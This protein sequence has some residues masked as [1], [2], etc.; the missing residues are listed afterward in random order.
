MLDKKKNLL[1]LFCWLFVVSMLGCQH[2]P[3]AQ[4]D[5]GTIL[6]IVSDFNTGWLH[7][8][9]LAIKND[10]LKGGETFTVIALNEP[11]TYYEGRV[12]EK[13][14]SSLACPALLPD[15][16]DTN[17]AEGYTCYAVALPKQ[18]SLELGIAMV[19]IEP[20]LQVTRGI[21]HGDINGDYHDNYFTQCNTSEGIRFNIWSD[22]AF[23]GDPIWSGYYYL[24]YDTES[25]CP[26]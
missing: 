10:R 16:K 23:K 1:L 21:V 18:S 8:N 7:G 4:S 20:T 5:H 19:G 22:E 13:T 25:N 24:G 12:L 11:Q 15:R 17:L 3:Q 9:C 26:D 14:M 6:K 2:R